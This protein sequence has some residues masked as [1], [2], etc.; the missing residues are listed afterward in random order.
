M[1]NSMD[2][3]QPVYQLKYGQ[4]KYVCK[5]FSSLEEIYKDIE[6]GYII[7]WQYHAVFVGNIQQ[8]QC[9]WLSKEKPI[10]DE[11]HIVRLRAFNQ[12]KEWHIWKSGSKLLCRKREETQVQDKEENGAQ[13]F[14]DTSMVLRTVI[15]APLIEYELFKVNEK[16]KLCIKTRNYIDFDKATNQAGYIDSRFVDIYFKTF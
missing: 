9:N 12:S 11:I 8:E 13:C 1:N 4:S 6:K 14:I 10:I 2:E 16:E 5:P 15:A 7:L 3:L